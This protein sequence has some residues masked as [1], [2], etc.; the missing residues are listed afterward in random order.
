VTDKRD[1]VI[2]HANAAAKASE[3]ALVLTLNN[4]NGNTY[5]DLLQ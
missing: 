4:V 5:L 2:L 1:K 3:R